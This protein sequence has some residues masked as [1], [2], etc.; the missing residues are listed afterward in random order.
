MNSQE[1][2]SLPRGSV[3]AVLAILLISAI[4]AAGIGFV[5]AGYLSAETVFTGILGLGTTVTTFYFASRPN[6][7]ALP[8]VLVPSI[9]PVLVEPAVGVEEPVV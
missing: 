5:A 7:P 9:P 8:P 3:R 4:I 1:P 6:T 2:L